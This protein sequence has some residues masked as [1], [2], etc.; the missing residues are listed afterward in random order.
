[1]GGKKNGSEGEMDVTATVDLDR[2]CDL[3]ITHFKSFITEAGLSDPLSIAESAEH[4]LGVIKEGNASGRMGSEETI[5]DCGGLANLALAQL[6]VHMVARRFLIH[7]DGSAPA[8]S[9]H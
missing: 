8:S 1:M 9:V 7:D 4:A 6:L 2:F 5:S 3:V